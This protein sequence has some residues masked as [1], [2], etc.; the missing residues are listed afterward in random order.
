[1]TRS[2]AALLV[3]LPS[4]DPAWFLRPDGSDGSETIHGLAHTRRVTALAIALAERLGVEPWQREAV[5]RAALWHD[6]GRTHDGGDHLHGGKSAGKV[7]GLGLHR[8]LEP[9]VVEVALHA[10]TFH[11]TADRY[12]EESAAYLVDPESG[13]LVFKLLKD[14]DALDRVRFGAGRLDEAQ[15]RLAPSRGLVRDAWGLLAAVPG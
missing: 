12:G 4:P 9:R 7:V 8:G 10:V 3:A 15:L 11:S 14:A 6:I 13:L 5:L 2:L 1:M